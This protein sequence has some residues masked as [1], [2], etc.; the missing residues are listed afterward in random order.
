VSKIRITCQKITS[1]FLIGTEHSAGLVFWGSLRSV[2][3]QDYALGQKIEDI[4]FSKNRALINDWMRGQKSSEELNTFLSEQLQTSPER[5]W[6]IFLRDCKSMEFDNQLRKKIEQIKT[7]AHVVLVTGNMDCFTRYTVPALALEKVFDKIINSSDLGY[8]KTEKEG[9]TFL[10]CVREYDVQISQTFLIDDSV[11]TCEF[12]NSLGGK[13]YPVLKGKEDTLRFMEVL[14]QA[15]SNKSEDTIPAIDAA[16]QIQ[17]I[18]GQAAPEN[19][20]I[21]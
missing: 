20:K 8:L 9:E 6:D 16:L 4:L 1:F 17:E 12:F 21:D 19:F 2:D 5:L 11:K 14:Y 7:R 15:T 18:R 3:S 10:A 13:S